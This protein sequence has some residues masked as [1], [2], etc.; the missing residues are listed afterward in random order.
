M[1]GRI[2]EGRKQHAPGSLGCQDGE[3]GST[4][5]GTMGSESRAYVLGPR[6]GTAFWFVGSLIDCAS[7]KSKRQPRQVAFPVV[8]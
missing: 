8:S 7:L 4:R 3:A 5:E 1:V 6:E 2:L